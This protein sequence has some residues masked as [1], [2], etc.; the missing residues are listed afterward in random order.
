M[1]K[2]KKNGYY[3]MHKCIFTF[4]V[5][6]RCFCRSSHRRCFV[7]K[8]ILRNLA[9]FAEKH[10]CQGLRPVTLL[11]KRLWH[12]CFPVNFCKISKNT[13]F[14]EHVWATATTFEVFAYLLSWNYTLTFMLLRL[15]IA[16]FKTS[17][18]INVVKLHSFVPSV[19]IGQRLRTKLFN[20]IW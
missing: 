18:K 3:V 5:L 15:K 16:S 4:L 9:K 10:L 19:N 6:L 8:S 1:S 11:K 13:F 20:C 17:L 7:R 12:R 2:S 14:T